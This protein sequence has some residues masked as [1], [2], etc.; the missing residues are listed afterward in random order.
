MVWVVLLA[1]FSLLFAVWGYVSA[2]A[3]GRSPVLWALVCA[4]TFF[5][6]IAIVYSLNEPL[7]RMRQNQRL[8]GD[9]AHDE[10]MSDLQPH[11]DDAPS[12]LTEQHPVL[13]GV[14]PT[15][16]QPSITTG[17]DTQDRRWR[18]LLEYH[19]D[20]DKAVRRIQPLGERALG[21][22]KTAYLTLNDSA[23]LPAIVRRLEE[24]FGSRIPERAQTTEVRRAA[25]RAVNED[26]PIE[27]TSPR[28]TE[29]TERRSESAGGAAVSRLSRQES[30]SAG[31]DQAPPRDDAADLESEQSAWRAAFDKT[32]D[33]TAETASITAVT[34]S[35]L[36]ELTNDGQS[37][38]ERLQPV[39]NGAANG[40]F[41]SSNDRGS[42]SGAP[43]HRQ[44]PDRSDAR[45]L[46]SLPPPPDEPSTRRPPQHR[47]VA[48]AELAGAR[49]VETH[50]G[51]HLFALA[52]G[53]V[54]VD[55]H[56]ALAS[57]QQA[58]DYVDSIKAAGYPRT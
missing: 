14:P 26:E 27:L 58:R 43:S 7:V 2:R 23:L 51:L 29:R 45:S 52:D 49:Y 20:I 16:G 42:A 30:K 21:E 57:L 36:D 38:A 4:L 9:A 10:S 19:P 34:S 28:A 25:A 22:L 44:E 5:I 1:A 11:R 46:R 48:P 12:L 24:R 32:D 56:E 6:G 8:H 50:G 40:S 15:Q 47:T 54:F 3:R 53:R 35:L 13:T 41:T 31:P 55:R 39:V 17:E 33:K 37:T 18:Y